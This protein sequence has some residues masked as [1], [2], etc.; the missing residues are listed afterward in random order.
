VRR[1]PRE[2]TPARATGKPDAGRVWRKPPAERPG[3]TS[4]AAEE[5][6]LLAAAAAAVG[7]GGYRRFA[8][9]PAHRLGRALRSKLYKLTRQLPED[10]RD[11]LIARIKSAA[12][13]STAALAAGFGEGTTRSAIR[14]A[15]ASRGALVAVQDHLDLAA[16]QQ[17]LAADERQALGDEI[18]EMIAAVNTYLGELVRDSDR[19]GGG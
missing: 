14:G 1:R 15:L 12:T 5:Q 13:S 2:E 4:A 8:D 16:E 19:L 3:E 9:I 18:D 17:W 6:K 10:E 11:N 7:P